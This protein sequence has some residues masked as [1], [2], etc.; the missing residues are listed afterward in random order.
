VGGENDVEKRKEGV[1]QEDN[2]DVD[3]LFSPARLQN[4]VYQSATAMTPDKKT[5]GIRDSF[6]RGMKTNSVHKT[7]C[8]KKYASSP[9]VLVPRTAF[10]SKPPETKAAE[11][12]P[13]WG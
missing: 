3:E 7:S 4:V 8:G 1:G 2:G 10:G 12:T 11:R 5:R 6:E 9:L 13:P